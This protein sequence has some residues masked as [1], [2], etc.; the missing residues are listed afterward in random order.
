LSDSITRARVAAADGANVNVP[1][2]QRLG[3]ATLIVGA[4]ATL[5]VTLQGKMRPVEFDDKEKK[6]QERATW[7]RRVRF[8]LWGPGSGF[9][10]IAFWAIALSIAGT[11]LTG[12]KQVYDPTRT[13]TQNTR[14]MLELRQLHQDVVM[15]VKCDNKS[16]VTNTKMPVWV[17][18]LRRIRGTIIPDWGAYANLDVGNSQRPDSSQTA[19]PASTESPKAP[20]APEPAASGQ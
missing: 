7:G 4:L 1:W 13:L 12:L 16:I 10:W 17:E 2:V 19:Q 14:A 11:A 9:R 5:F 18:T 6:K 3:I 8:T 20:S 15:G